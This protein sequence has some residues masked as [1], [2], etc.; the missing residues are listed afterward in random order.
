MA[1]IRDNYRVGNDEKSSHVGSGCGGGNVIDA[2]AYTGENGGGPYNGV[3][4]GVPLYGDH[5]NAEL[6]RRFVTRGYNDVW[7]A[8][9]FVG[10]LL[11]CLVWAI[12]NGVTGSVELERGQS[13]RNETLSD[14]AKVGHS[15]LSAG[16]LPLGMLLATVLAMASLGLMRLYPRQYIWGANLLGVV[17]LV[18]LGIWQG[19]VTKQT[20]AGVPYYLL[21]FFVL[22]Y[23]LCTLRRIPFA[24][25]LL[26]NSVT[27]VT[28]HYGSIVTSGG[29]VVL[30][31]VYAVMFTAMAAPTLRTLASRSTSDTET[32]GNDAGDGGAVAVLLLFLLMWYWTGQVLVNVVHVTASGTVATW[33]FVGASSMPRNPS[34][35]SLKRALTTS[36]GSICFGSLLVALLKLLYFMAHS[37]ASHRQAGFLACLA[38]CVVGLLERLLEYFNVYALTHVAIYGSPF[39]EAAKQTWRLVKSCLAAAVFN[40]NLVFPVLNITTVVNSLLVGLAVGT[41]TKNVVAAIVCGL[42]SWMV[43][44]VILRVVYSGIVTIFVCYAECPEALEESNPVLRAEIDAA[45]A[46]ASTS[47]C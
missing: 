47:T 34:V 44:V 14:D 32:S 5:E 4:E 41:A 13:D 40:D 43:H 31:F 3:V 19:H 38:L 24:A 6:S 21:A 42:L 45:A 22:A 16:G 28:R 18:V 12:H 26:R 1:S 35:A 9:L 20:G 29:T 10:Q 39:I 33:Y 27:V 46:T 8:V 2:A 23:F 7:A 15:L 36:F 11:V 37:A 25:V 30:A 17:L